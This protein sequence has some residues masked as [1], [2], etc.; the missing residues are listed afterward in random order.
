MLSRSPLHNE[1]WLMQ[2]LLNISISLTCLGLLTS[3]VRADSAVDS[4]G[5]LLRRILPQHANAFVLQLIAK[6]PAGDVFEIEGVEGKIVLRG[7]N[8]VS[9]ASA[10][11]WYLKHYCHAHLSWCGDQLSLPN[12]LPVVPE[13]VRQVSPFRY[14]YCFNYCAFSYSLAWWDWPRWERMI[15]WMALHGINMPLAITGQE[16]VWMEVYRQLGLTDQQIKEFFVGPAFLP[17]GWMGCLDG[18]GGPLPDR[19]IQRHADLERRI[20]ERE[21]SLGMTPVLQ[22]FTGHVPAALTNAFPQSKLQQ[23]PK[24]CEFPATYFVDPQD[25][26]FVK[27]GQRFIE[28]QTRQFGTDHLYASDTFIE[29]QPPSNDPAFL[30][31]MGRT[32]YEAMR[33]GDPE[34]VWVLQGWLFVN[35]PKFWQ[36][37]QGRAL[38]SAVPGDRLIALDLFCESTPAWSQTEAFYGKP[39][40]W[41]IIQNFGGT[42]SLHG[43]LP[44]MAADLSKAL[45]SPERGQLSGIGLIFEGL[46][47]NPIVQDFVT[48]MTWRQSVPDLKA[49]TSEFIH[50]RYGRQL[51]EVNAAWQ[52]LLDTVYQEV[53]RSD[54]LLCSRPSAGGMGGGSGA[55]DPSSLLEACEKLLAGAK[56]LG[57][58]DTY[59][60]D[61]VNVTRQTLGTVA[62]PL[63][64][65]L[66]SAVRRKDADALQQAGQDMVQLCQDLDEL[67]ATRKEFLLG[68]WLADAVSWAETP[69]QAR[70]FEWNGRNLITL[71]GPRDSVLHEYASRQWSGMFAG[72]YGRRWQLFIDRQQAGLVENRPFD[73]AR[74]ERDVH[75]WEE[76]WTH[77]AQPYPVEARGDAVQV[78]GRLLDRYKRLF[79]PD[80]PSLTSGRPVTCSFA[81]PNYPAKL[82][83]DGRRSS[84]D[85]YWAT[86]VTQDRAAWWQVD[87]EKPTTVGRVVVVGYYGD[88][89][90]YGFTVDVSQDGADWERVADRRDNREPSTAEGYTCSFPPRPVRFI[91][92]TQTHNSANTGRHLVE[93]MAYEN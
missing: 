21:R 49:W 73:P 59:Q 93:V 44:R 33:A 47:Y 23:L 1:R 53:G 26:L 39:W 31:N 45:T 15:D 18:W 57:R 70:L 65:R 51:P 48:D 34:A 13:K 83:N 55:Y 90:A 76:N 81:L 30:A 84:T 72:F 6:D 88:Q 67:L 25:P 3:L 37:P 29:M 79:E 43:A 46:D 4:A 10:L 61:V 74:F 71:W 85:R 36:P 40:I 22:G 12:P 56:E 17:F 58:L 11:N 32:V 9:L 69:A 16:A 14:R 64:E 75:A 7:N 2:R 8:G 60:F 62:A 54:T 38:L 41:C 42:V 92:V 87:L 80:V 35:N 77:L 82:A 68:R 91:R 19:W 66:M 63:Y 28:E 89:R 86:D 27:I 20:L 24:W 5:A 52:I 50:R 78:A